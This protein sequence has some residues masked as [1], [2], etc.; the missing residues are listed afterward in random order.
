[1]NMLIGSLLAKPSIIYILRVDIPLMFFNN[2]Y[3]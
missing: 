2:C 3:I 1:L